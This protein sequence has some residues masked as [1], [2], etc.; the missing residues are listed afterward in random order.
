M[1][2]IWRFVISAAAALMGVWGYYSFLVT[3]AA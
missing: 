1:D 2:W 3:P